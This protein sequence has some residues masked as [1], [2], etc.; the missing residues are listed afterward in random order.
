M[1]VRPYFTKVIFKSPIFLER[2]HEDICEPIHPPCGP[3]CYFMILIDVFTMW[4]N[5]CLISTRN[6]AFARFLAHSPDNVNE[7]TSQ[8][9]INYCMSI[10]INIEHFPKWFSRVFYQTSPINSLTITNEN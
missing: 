6:V 7:F 2:I 4:S 9:F 10:E 1:I 8:T 3:F 5:V